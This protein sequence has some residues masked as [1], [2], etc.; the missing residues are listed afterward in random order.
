MINWAHVTG[1]NWDEGNFRKS[2]DKH[3]VGQSEAEEVFFNEPLLLLEDA[4]HSQT[5]ARFHAL[6][7]TDDGRLLHITF[8]LRQSGTLIR[9][10]SARDMHRKER[11]VY[12]QAKKDA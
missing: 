8:T 9:V 3:G 11:A 10:I 1:F 4:K 5:E 7:K 2:A 12:E 6:G